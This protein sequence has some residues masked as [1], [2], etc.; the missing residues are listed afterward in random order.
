VSCFFLR[1][2]VQRNSAATMSSPRNSSEEDDISCDWLKQYLTHTTKS[3]FSAD[4]VKEFIGVQLH[5]NVFAC[6]ACIYSKI[7]PQIPLKSGDHFVFQQDG[8]P[9]H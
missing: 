5:S 2:S 8:V 6:G 1:H 3:S 9:S 4:S 7:F